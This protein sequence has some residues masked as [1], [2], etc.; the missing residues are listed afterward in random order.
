[1]S[2]VPGCQ[3]CDTNHLP[4][5][6]PQWIERTTI[7]LSELL[8]KIHDHCSLASNGMRVEIGRMYVVDRARN[9][10]KVT[11]LIRGDLASCDNHLHHQ[12]TCSGEEAFYVGG[13]RQLPATVHSRFKPQTFLHPRKNCALCS[14]LSSRWVCFAHRFV[15][16]LFTHEL[17]SSL[18][19]RRSCHQPRKM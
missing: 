18:R 7:C 1:M 2:Y 12:I 5:M 9:P 16:D 11:S 17:C 19:R 10:G 14:I 13:K 8:P 6:T 15:T 3:V 4:H